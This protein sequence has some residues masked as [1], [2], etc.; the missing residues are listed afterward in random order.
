MSSPPSLRPQLAP[1]PKPPEKRQDSRSS[2]YRDHNAGPGYESMPGD[3]A[4]SGAQLLGVGKERVGQFP[5]RELQP[6]PRNLSSRTTLC[7]T[8]VE[9]AHVG[10]VEIRHGLGHGAGGPG[11]EPQPPA[12]PPPP[13]ASPTPAVRAAQARSLPLRKGDLG[14]A[15]QD[16]VR[17]RPLRVSRPLWEFCPLLCCPGPDSEA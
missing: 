13:A 1:R 10:V 2:S 12:R 14:P 5:P 15:S 17:P 6:F 16:H 8:V 9:V 11:P 4:S 7:P 3:G